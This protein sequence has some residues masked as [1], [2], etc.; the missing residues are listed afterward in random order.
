MI[1]SIFAQRD[2]TIYE[3]QYTMNT[4]ID[5]LLELSH[6]TPGSG[7]SIYNSRIL[8]K[9]DMSD[10]ENRINS[11][12]I[13]ENA[14]YYLSLIT[15]DIREI[16]QEYVIYAYPLS[17]SWTNGTGRFVN[18]PYTTDGVSWRYR[19]SK[20]VGTEWDIPP[21][22][23]SLEWDEISQTWVD[24]AILFG[25]NYISATVTSSYF[26]HEGGGTWWDYDNLECTQS[27]SFQ[28][29][30]IYMDVT[31]IARK[32][33]TGSGRFENDGILLKFSNE[34]ESS[35]DNLL[36]SLK[37]FGTDSNTIYVPRLN[38]VWDDSEFITGSLQPVAEDNMN[39]NVKLKKFYAEKERSKI[40]IYANSRYP[41]KNY[42]TTAYQ[43]VNYYLPSSSYYEIRDAHSDEII[44]PFDYTGSKISCDGTS[45]YF[46]LWMDSFQPER[47]YRVVIKV[48]RE[49]GDNVQIF[50]NNHY[51][52][53]VR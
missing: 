42:T 47:F 9:F 27:F 53:V 13:S 41:Q 7:S 21:G 15:A 45:S 33:V 3:R 51:F 38:I 34:I 36:N 52:K 2:A 24:A 12:K 4:G 20:T 1:Y 17:S 46:N 6:E 18:L 48:E 49:D 22:V 32:W 50:D 39:L 10:V 14:K 44:L 8:L 35:P 30:D 19:T 31:N 5:P 43:T 37:F 40:R 11:G 16:P 23:A 25:T 26:T 29:S 28:S